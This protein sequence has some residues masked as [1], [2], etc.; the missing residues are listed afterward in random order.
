MHSEGD[1]RD[2]SAVDDLRRRAFELG[3]EVGEENHL[4]SVGWVN[5]KLQE[6]RE[7]ADRVGVFEEVRRAYQKGKKLGVARR[8]GHT[9]TPQLGLVKDRSAL[10]GSQSPRSEPKGP[11]LP[12]PPGFIER[13]PPVEGLR[14]T[15]NVM[16]FASARPELKKDL[17]GLVAGVLDIQERLIDVGARDPPRRTFERSLQLL[18]EIG[19]IEDFALTSFDDTSAVVTLKSTIANALGRSAEPLCKPICS[20]LETM[21]RKAFGRSVKVVEVECV[22]QGKQAC[23]FEVSLRGALSSR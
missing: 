1:R 11:R 13:I 17:N 3:L 19:W 4:E 22:A 8:S 18:E 2:D 14:S 23:K 5:S 10:S 7:E 9:L 20:L 16:M 21:G 15:I 6:I 12:K